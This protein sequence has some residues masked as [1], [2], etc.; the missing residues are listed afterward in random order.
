MGIFD[1]FSRASAQRPNFQLGG[2]LNLILRIA[3]KLIQD[4][5]SYARIRKKVMQLDP[6]ILDRLNSKSYVDEGAD[7]K[8]DKKYQ[9]VLDKIID[10]YVPRC[11]NFLKMYNQVLSDLLQMVAADE[12]EEMG[13]LRSLGEILNDCLRIPPRYLPFFPG[14]V[15]AFA[16]ESRKVLEKLKTEV[17]HEMREDE[18]MKYGAHPKVGFRRRFFMG[19]KGLAKNM[20][21]LDIRMKKSGLYLDFNKRWL[22][23]Q[24]R[25]GALRQGF[26]KRLLTYLQNE[27]LME[28]YIKRIRADVME[29]IWHHRVEHDK[30]VA[31]I[32]PIYKALYNEPR[33]SAKIRSIPDF[34]RHFIN[35]SKNINKMNEVIRIINADIMNQRALYGMVSYDIDLLNRFIANMR[36]NASRMIQSRPNAA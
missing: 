2:D 7:A 1:M 11:F 15:E 19:D 8:A 4:E 14:T 32:N 24:A 25:T 9:K 5:K 16:S 33:L 34:D 13:E 26:L 17:D 36:A 30:V 29:L 6:R 28:L 12:H 3:N 10:D 35:Y 20:R 22:I 31:V 27:G 21:R 18:R 23:I